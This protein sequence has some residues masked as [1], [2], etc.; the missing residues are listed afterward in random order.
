VLN[1]N[2]QVEL[3]AVE[4]GLRGEEWIEILSGVEPGERVVTEGTRLLSDGARA[5][6]V[7]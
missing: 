2:D 6:V 1:G 4:V 7:D 5:R 3:R